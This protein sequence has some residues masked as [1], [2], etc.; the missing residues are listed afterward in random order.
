MDEYFEDLQSGRILLRDK[1][2]FE[3]K[4]DL[5]TFSHLRNNIHSQEFYF[6]IPNSLQINDQ[7]YTKAQFYLDQTNLI[8]FKS[9]TFTF[10]ELIDPDNT[11]SPLVRIL[12]LEDVVHSRENEEL[13]EDE[14]KLLANIFHSAIRTRV[15]DL[16]ATLDALQTPEDKE[17]FTQDVLRFCD[18][19]NDF[20]NRYADVEVKCIDSW[21]SD[22]LHYH[23]DYVDEFISVD[24]SDYLSGFLHRMRLKFYQELKTADECLCEIILREKKYREVKFKEPANVSHDQQKDE[25]LLYR[26]G[27]LN[28]FVIDP[29]L[30]KTSRAPIDQRYRSFILGIPAA[31]AMMIF[32]FLYIWQG[33]VFLANSQPF[34]VA[35]VILYVLKDRM[36]EELRQLS[37][38]QAAK[39]FSDYT[40]QIKAPDNDAVLGNIH[41]SFS[42]V[43]ETRVPAEIMH[44]RNRE[45]REILEEVK[46][47]EQII[48]YKKTVNIKKKPKRIEARF[49]GFSIIFRFD[50]HNF[51][52]KAEDP[53][54]ATLTL[55]P[56]ELTLRREQL[57]RVYHLN[58]IIKNTIMMPEGEV[59]VELKK[60]RLIIDKNGIKRVEPV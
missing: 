38:R 55:D 3:L 18:E 42:F 32:M 51:L 12:L 9:P 10:K 54:Q 6:F 48:Y 1:W 8:R 20:R 59:R 40:T 14:I 30:L 22:L 39:W 16:I 52:V 4:S 23:F 21:P 37:Y 41:E 7:T 47:P 19:I 45:F 2:Q 28:K 5:F 60:F 46:R 24:I 33:N 57:P 25:Y 56:G 27:L 34:I 44:I 13:V 49:Y 50:I 31:L 43:K 53:Y 58:I 15:A 26:K 35:T 29:L 36:K 11:E 17:A